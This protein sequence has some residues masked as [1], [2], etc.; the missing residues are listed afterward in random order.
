MEKSE[1]EQREENERRL[2]GLREAFARAASYHAARK[3]GDAVAR[4][5]RWD[6]MAGVL[7]SAGEDQ[8]PVFLEANEV[9]QIRSALRFARKRGLRPVIVGGRDAWLCA[10]MLKEVGAKVIV[11]GTYEM[12]H[13]ADAP[14]DE[15]FRLPARLEA[16]GIPWCLAS[17]QGPANERNLPYAAAMAVAHG[18]SADAAIRS[19]T[20]SA[21]EILGVAD[22]LGS[23]EPG[24]AATLIVTDGDPLEIPTNVTAAFID[25]REVSLENKQTALAEKYA[26]PR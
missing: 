9:D 2:R 3:A 19:I 18:L 14:V 15:R 22:R 21:A 16:A 4:D 5:V 26:R 20:L 10:P 24:K 11:T 13:R 1:E 12:P 23:L 7:P 17:G 6:A 25:G 8:K